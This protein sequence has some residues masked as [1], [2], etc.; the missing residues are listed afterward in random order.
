[1]KNIPSKAEILAWIRDHPTCSTRRDIAKAFGIKGAER[2]L[3]GRILRELEEE[4]H[5][6]K[7]RSSRRERQDLPPVAV[8]RV[9]GVDELGDLIAR[10]LGWKGDGEAPLVLL[11]PAERGQSAGAGDQVLARLRQVPDEAHDYEGQIIRKIGSGPRKLLGIFRAGSEG[12]RILPIEKGSDREWRVATRDM[13]GARDGELVEAEQSGPRGRLGLP[14]ARILARLGDPTAPK[15]V[16]LIAIHHHGL[17]DDFPPQVLGE[18]DDISQP[19]AQ[20]RI[21]LRHVPLV[22]IDPEDARDHDDAVHA[23]PDPDDANPGGFILWVAIADVAHY[24]RPGSAIDREARRRGNST[25]FPDR[26]VP[27][28]PERLSGDLCSLHEGVERPCIALRM[29]IDRDGNKL[30]HEFMRALMRSPAALTYAQVQSAMDGGTPL[31]QL[32]TVIRPLYGAYAALAQARARRQPLDLDLPERKIALGEDGKV[33]SV[34]FTE[35]LD[36]HRLIEEF[37][38]LANVAAAQTLATRRVPFLYRVHEE[39]APDRLDAL[40]ETVQAAGLT[41]AKGQVLHTRHLNALLEQ[42]RGTAENELINLAT[43]RSMT[44]AYYASQN[45]GHFGLALKDYAHFTSPIRR[46]A[47][48]IVHRAL[49][50]AHGWGDDGLSREDIEMLEKT[51]QMISESERRSMMAERDTVDRYLAAYLADRAGAD[52]TGTVSGIAKFGIFVKLDETGADGL[53]PMRALGHEYFHHDRERGTLRGE[54]SGRMI[55]VGLRARVRLREAVAVTGGIA[56]DL[57]ELDGDEIAPGRT[58]GKRRFGGPPRRKAAQKAGK[59]K[60]LKRKHRRG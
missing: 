50:T 14:S 33:A 25:Y 28:L 35:R 21:D 46:Y 56:L 22:T 3:F 36:A 10:P 13:A 41:L 27:M 24:V 60:K 30:G 58:R 40:R 44:Q 12:G 47:D 48:L 42:A 39:P 8:L 32:D 18:L 9:T 31:P 16:S 51:A 49:I 29:V 17:A 6:Q 53:V 5:L 43:L 26:V 2:P 4:G 1:M 52:F 54:Q 34:D 37:M 7:R 55:R 38:V 57:L 23:E 45:F 15:A 20:G 59:D 11:G 19:D